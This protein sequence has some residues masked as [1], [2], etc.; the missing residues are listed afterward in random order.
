MPVSMP[1]PKDHKNFLEAAKIGDL[2][3]IKNILNMNFNTALPLLPL[4]G[5][6]KL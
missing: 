2:E 5:I 1:L 3:K 4:G 6:M